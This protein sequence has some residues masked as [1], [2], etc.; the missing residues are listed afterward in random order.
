LGQPTLAIGGRGVAVVGGANPD[1]ARL[2]LVDDSPPV[3]EV[4]GRMLGHLGHRVVEA[5]SGDEALDAYRAERPDGVFLDLTMPGMG[6]LEVLRELLALDPG[7]RVAVL[8]SRRDATTV[9]AALSAGARD[10]V[11]KPATLGRLRE[12]CERVL[13]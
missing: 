2:L 7:A 12:A 5:A 3:L 13:A 6:G 9:Q 10:Y 4:F 1:K 11:I 8:T